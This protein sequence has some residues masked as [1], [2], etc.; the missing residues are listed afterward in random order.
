[1]TDIPD[2]ELVGIA[3]AQPRDSGLSAMALGAV[4]TAAA[5]LLQDG[6][7]LPVAAH[8]AAQLAGFCGTFRVPP[9]SRAW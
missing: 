1:M 7:N 4:P 5:N 6:T 8:A 3:A 2:G 9:V